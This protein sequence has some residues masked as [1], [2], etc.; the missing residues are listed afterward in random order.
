MPVIIMTNE[1]YKWIPFYMEFADK[2]LEYKNNRTELIEKI[3]RLWDNID[4]NMPTLEKDNDVIDIDPFT[5]FG[6]FN[7]ALTIKNRIS[8]LKFMK[9][10]FNI[11]TEVPSNFDGIPVINP[12]KATF[13]YFIDKRG[14]K[15]IDNLWNVFESAIDYVNTDNSDKFIDAYDKVMGQLGVKWNITMGLYWIRPYDFINLDQTNRDYLADNT[16]FGYEISNEVKSM[17]N[18]PK[19]IQYLTFT[20]KCKYFLNKSSKFN[21]LPELSHE[22]YVT[23]KEKNLEESTGGIGDSEDDNVVNYWLYAPGH[24]ANKWDK[25][26]KNGIMGIGWSYVGDLSEYN[27]KEDIVRKLQEIKQDN[28]KYTNDSLALWQFANEIKQGDIIFAKKGIHEIVGYGVVESEYFYDDTFDNEHFH[29]LKVDWKENGNYNYDGNLIMKTLTKITDYPALVNTINSFFESSPEDEEP[30]LEYPVYTIDNFLEEAYISEEEY[31]ILSNLLKYKK[32][33]ILQGAPGVGKTFISK[34]LAYSLLGCKDKSKVTLVQFHQSYSYEDFIM[35]YRPSGDGF[36]LKTGVFYN[37]CKKAS[38]DEEN[39]YYFI[40]D[41]INRGNLSKIFGELFMLIENDKRGIKNKI[42][43]LYNDEFFYI[44]ENV[45]IIGMMNT[46]DRGLALVDYA[47]R[48]RFAFYS[49]EPSFDSVNFTEYMNNLNNIKFN[50]LIGLIKELNAEISSDE[51]LGK[52]FMIGHSY[53]TNLKVGRVEEKLYYIIEYEIIPL[54]EEYW[55][56]E[57]DKVESWKNKLRS[58]TI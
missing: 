47:L 41:E 32:N 58:V 43:L 30:I 13:Y 42:Q 17:K 50:N 18:P 23:S 28:S 46:A 44:P 48:R 14:E 8:I 29:L 38:E 10:E 6:L 25:Y 26:Y 53:F 11:K 27:S 33:I 34:R 16:I 5:I 36:K 20:D 54:L 22:A 31:N 4:M 24:D 2:L 35:G 37:F 19:A 21:N 51:S 9:S 45:Y 15:D 49:L 52:G 56:D 12:Q 55:F 1:D 7:K 57:E 39:D 3:L 40:I